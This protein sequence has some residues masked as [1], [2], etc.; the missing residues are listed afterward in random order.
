MTTVYAIGTTNDDLIT[1]LRDPDPAERAE[2]AEAI[3]VLH[4][5]LALPH[6]LDTARSDP[7]AD[8]RETA[9]QAVIA[10]SPSDEAAARAIAG[11]APAG[12]DSGRSLQKEQ[13]AAVIALFNEYIA[14]RQTPSS[15]PAESDLIDPV[16]DYLGAWG[17]RSAQDLDEVGLAAAMAV[18]AIVRFLEIPEGDASEKFL[19][20]R[21]AG[22]RVAEYESVLGSHGEP[23]EG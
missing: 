18:G 10:L 3:G 20:F 17:G 4:V 19:S 16:I 5:Y 22:T 11:D 6:L 2:N 9:R 12:G 13:A 8:V 7:D 23:E 1:G 14:A 15:R 21:D